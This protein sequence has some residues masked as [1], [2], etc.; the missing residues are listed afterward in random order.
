MIDSISPKRPLLSYFIISDLILIYNAALIKFLLSLISAFRKHIGSI[1]PIVVCNWHRYD[2]SQKLYPHWKSS[3]SRIAL[4]VHLDVLS[5]TCPRPWLWRSCK[6]LADRTPA[7]KLLEPFVF[8]RFSQGWPLWSSTPVQ[9]EANPNVPQD[10][11][12]I[13]RLLWGLLCPD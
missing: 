1:V 4:L 6:E 12:D 11:Q 7:I 10:H 9:F 8:V 13:P 2:P 5:T 3:R